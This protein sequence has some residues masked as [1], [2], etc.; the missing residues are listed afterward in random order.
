MKYGLNVLVILASTVC[1][2]GNKVDKNDKKKSRT[3]AAELSNACQSLPKVLRVGPDLLKS[4][5]P[6]LSLSPEDRQHLESTVSEFTSNA[7]ATACRANPTAK[8]LF[9]EQLSQ[10]EVNSAIK[11][12]CELNPFFRLCTVCHRLVGKT[13]GIHIP[14]ANAMGSCSEWA[15]PEETPARNA[16]L[17]AGN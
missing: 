11:S 6:L 13:R 12:Y 16:A 5:V 17:E 14:L 9:K 2:A 1:L 10:E 7:V 8:Q 3:P 4:L 15:K